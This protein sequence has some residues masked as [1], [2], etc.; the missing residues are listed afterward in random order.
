M[1]FGYIIIF[2]SLL[3]LLSTPTNA[4]VTNLLLEE[5]VNPPCSL[6]VLGAGH[7]NDINLAKLLEKY[8]KIT[9][10]DIED[11]A[12]P[13]YGIVTTID[14]LEEGKTGNEALANGGQEPSSAGDPTDGARPSVSAAAISARSWKSS[15]KWR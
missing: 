8:E 3:L 12:G 14:D 4:S 5:A 13:A 11:D 9:L 6:C 2:A 7:C 10:A 15:G 1:T